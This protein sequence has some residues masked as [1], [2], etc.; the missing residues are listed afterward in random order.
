MEKILFLILPLLL[1]LGCGSTK[2]LDLSKLTT[3]MT[4]SEVAAVVGTPYRVLAVNDTKDGYQEVLEYRTAY[5]EVYALEFW[6]DY[7]TGFEFLYDDVEYVS[8]VA[9][10]LYWPERGR[11]IYVAPPGNRPNRPN[12]PNRP[13]RP[14]RPETNRPGRPESPSRPEQPSRP[15]VSRPELTKP[16]PVPT[17]R[18]TTRP[19]ATNSN[20]SRPVDRS[21]LAK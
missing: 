2:N 3:G 9:P 17:P 6:N 15:N 5:N 20:E 8:S 19:A 1:L 11:P 21:G 7:L 18:P 13:N 10:P 4:K 14:N 12:H 16:A